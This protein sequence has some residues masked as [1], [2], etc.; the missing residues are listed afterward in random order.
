MFKFE[1]R[2]QLYIFN[3]FDANDRTPFRSISSNP[4][5]SALTSRCPQPCP[6]QGSQLA[7][8]EFHQ[9]HQ[10]LVEWLANNY[11]SFG[12]TLEFVTNRS[13]EGSQ[14]CR[15]SGGI[16]GTLRWRVDFLEMDMAE[17]I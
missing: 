9:C 10:I 13:Q 17:D 1:T 5:P 2:Q 7:S 8:A 15:G 11:K 6:S 3:N 14:F 12:T 16:G 4:F